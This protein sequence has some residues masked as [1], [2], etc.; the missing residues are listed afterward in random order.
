[1]ARLSPIADFRLVAEDDDLLAAD[2]LDDFGAHNCTVYAWRTNT[3]LV[4]AVAGN[5]QDAIEIERLARFT[6]QAFDGNCVA[7]LDSVLLTACF[8][9]RVHSS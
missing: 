8:N 5:Q 4:V 6:G 9:N 7:W 1:M 3:G 2:M